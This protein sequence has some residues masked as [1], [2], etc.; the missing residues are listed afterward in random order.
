VK[1]FYNIP[2]DTYFELDPLSPSGLTWKIPRVNRFNNGL[3]IQQGSV[4]GSKMFRVGGEVLGWRVKLNG[5][6]YLNHRVIWWLLHKNLPLDMVVDHLDG[7]PL[8]NTHDNLAL[9]TVRCN[10]QNNKKYKSNSSGI[11]GVTLL[12]GTLKNGTLTER[13]VAN[14]YNGTGTRESKS[15]SVKKFGSD[16]AKNAAKEHRE[17]QIQLLNTLGQDYTERHKDAK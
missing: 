2:W 6:S 9:K 7:D 11:V 3:V 4:A 13:W 8:N 14:W 1:D 10:N 17:L 12:T 15:F 16:F 5:R